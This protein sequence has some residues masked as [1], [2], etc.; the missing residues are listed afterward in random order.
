M[1]I[2]IRKY[3]L[4]VIFLSLDCITSFQRIGTVVYYI[5]GTGPGTFQRAKAQCLLNML[6]IHNELCVMQKTG[7]GGWTGGRVDG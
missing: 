7:V 6:S 5:P 4:Y 3:G 1:Q 2:T